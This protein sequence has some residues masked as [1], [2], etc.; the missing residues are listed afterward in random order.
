MGT[1]IIS[2]LRTASELPSLPSS[3]GL[4]SDTV[5]LDVAFFVTAVIMLL[6]VALVI[7]TFGLLKKRANAQ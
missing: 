1:F 3:T 2:F 5:M 4:R 7:L 6:L